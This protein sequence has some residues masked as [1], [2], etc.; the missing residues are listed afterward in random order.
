MQTGSTYIGEKPLF[1]G[2]PMSTTLLGLLAILQYR[3]GVA[4]WTRLALWPEK[5]CTEIRTAR[6]ETDILSSF[7]LLSARRKAIRLDFGSS[8][9]QMGLWFGPDL[10]PRY[11]GSGVN[12]LQVCTC[13]GCRAASL[14]HL[15][16][17]RMFWC[18]NHL[19][20]AFKPC[21]VVRSS[22]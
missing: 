12:S 7:F 2:K 5:R 18:R 15:N 19:V 14:A 3:Y 11:P 22:M 17:C 13:T 6:A 20:T 16:C 21:C 9:W 10:V 8:S 4:V 1:R